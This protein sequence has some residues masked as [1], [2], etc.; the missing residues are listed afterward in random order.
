MVGT[1]GDMDQKINIQAA[2]GQINTLGDLAG[3]KGMKNI[4]KPGKDQHVNGFSFNSHRIATT[5]ALAFTLVEH[6]FHFIYG[7]VFNLT[8]ALA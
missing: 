4:F 1:V 8:H 5:F 7:L 2:G 3:I 6:F